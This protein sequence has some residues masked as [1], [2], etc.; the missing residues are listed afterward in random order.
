MLPRRQKFFQRA[1]RV[2]ALEKSFA[3]LSDARLREAA[4]E[5]RV[6]FRRGRDAPDDLERAF[7]MVR[8]VAR[9]QLGE[10]Q[11]LWER[12]GDQALGDIQRLAA[13]IIREIPAPALGGALGADHPSLQRGGQLSALQDHLSALRD[14]G[15]DDEEVLRHILRASC[16][17]DRLR[18]QVSPGMRN[19]L[20]DIQPSELPPE[21]R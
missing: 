4:D 9:R 7:A 19:Q 18:E 14:A 13:G 2:V 12:S 5:L 20:T 17:M 10:M 21:E 15:G 1:G 6:I 3:D 11:S 16:W 8:E